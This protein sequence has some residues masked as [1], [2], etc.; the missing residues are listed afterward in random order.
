M[1]NGAMK[2]VTFE[3]TKVHF[4]GQTVE[5][6][7]ETLNIEIKPGYG[8]HTKLVYPGRGDEVNGAMPSDLVISLK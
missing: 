6:V 2:E 8:P 7:K 4:D 1:Y 5:Q 3:R